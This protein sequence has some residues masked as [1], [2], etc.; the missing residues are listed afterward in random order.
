MKYIFIILLSLILFISCNNVDKLENYNCKIVEMDELSTLK[1]SITIRIQNQLSEDEL[2]EVALYLRSQ[3]NKYERL[4]INYYLRDMKIGSGSWATTH[5]KPTLE[6]IIQG[7][8]K[9]EEEIM[10][11][12]DL[13]SGEIIGKWYDTSFMLEHSIIIYLVDGQYRQLENYKDGRTNDQLLIKSEEE[14]KVKFVYDN[15]FGEY[16]LLES[17]NKLGLYDSDGLISISQPIE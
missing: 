6:V 15:S 12:I 3:N 9:D 4:F 13:P 14:A 7:A 5:F 2:E 8:T 17:D 1:K 16:Y 11:A 10:K